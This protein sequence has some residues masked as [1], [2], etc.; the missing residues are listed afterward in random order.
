[1]AIDAGR[2]GGYKGVT[3]MAAPRDRTPTTPTRL[4]RGKHGLSPQFVAS[5]QRERLISATVKVVAEKG[6][7]EATVADILERSGVS[8]K[9]FYDLF[10]NKEDCFL[11]TYDR[12]IDTLA[13]AVAD[14]FAGAGSWPE[15]IRG[16]LRALLEMLA[17][18]PDGARV[19]LV[20]VL[21]AGP[22][23]L[24]RYDAAIRRFVPL[25]EQGRA[26]SP[27]GDQLPPN[28]SEAVLGGIAQVL[29]LRVLAGETATLPEL[30]DELLYF[31]LVPYL[32]HAGTTRITTA[33]RGTETHSQ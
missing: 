23:A 26:E 28:I 14:S 16:G 3:V 17:A 9:T 31:A 18:R 19:G 32:G 5:N 20:E 24:E 29:Y 25:F 15:R 6:Y 4:P 12:L 2:S 22:R 33:R 8:R 7:A 27:Y 10:T 21:A 30:L 11:S 1:V 13:D